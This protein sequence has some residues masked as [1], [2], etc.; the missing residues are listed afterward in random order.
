MSS[1]SSV[2]IHFS[3]QYRRNRIAQENSCMVCLPRQGENS[4]RYYKHGANSKFKYKK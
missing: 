3:T 4:R 2:N 1:Q